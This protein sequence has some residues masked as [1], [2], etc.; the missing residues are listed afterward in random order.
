MAS[1]ETFNNTNVIR[2][3]LSSVLAAYHLEYRNQLR[4]LDGALRLPFSH[5]GATPDAPLAQSRAA[6]E[7]PTWPYL[8]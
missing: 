1:T 4:A 3:F 8:E 7:R 6:C 5:Q 2:V